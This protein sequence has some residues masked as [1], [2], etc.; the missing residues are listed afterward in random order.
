[1]FQ[2]QDLEEKNEV[3]KNAFLYLLDKSAGKG[4]VIAY[5]EPLVQG[6][7]WGILCLTDRS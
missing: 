1:M 6:Q 7:R 5:F 4:M 3:V 2:F